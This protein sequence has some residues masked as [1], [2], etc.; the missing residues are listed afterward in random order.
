MRLAVL[1]DIHGN[2]EALHRVLADADAQQAAH[3]V[4][5][6]DCIGYGPEP[7]AVIREIRSRRIPAIIGNHE[8][9][10]QDR[11]CLKWFNFMARR[12]LE[13]TL[14]MLSTESLAYI[15]ALPFSRLINESRFVHG[16]PPDSART[17]LFEVPDS[18]LRQT[19]ETMA[20]RICFVGH[21]HD[22]ELIRYDGCRTERRPLNEGIT[23]L[24]SDGRYLVN[25]GSVGQPRDG[26][27]HAKYVIWDS[28]EA[29][30]ETR[31]VSYD[32]AR[33]AAGIRAAGLP[34]A[35]ARCLM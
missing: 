8:M 32:I 19:L 26:T 15:R 4:C 11:I 24:L 6:G 16:F 21:T 12:S 3:M 17:Y 1:S 14:A 2:L 9:V 30:I 27:S 13:K 28:D 31:F 34:E 7:E 22:L 35:H 33:T 5:L 23:P 20:E 10:V 29:R 25:V 18:H